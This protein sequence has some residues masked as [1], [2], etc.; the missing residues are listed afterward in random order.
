MPASRKPK[1]SARANPSALPASPEVPLIIRS[2]PPERGDVLALLRAQALALPG[3]TERAVYDVFCKEWTPAYYVGERQLFHVHNFKTGLRGT[4]FVGVRTLLP[5]VLDSEE[6][7]EELRALAA[8][9][10]GGHT[11][12]VKVPL[13]TVDAVV[14]FLE[15]VRV[16]WR[17]LTG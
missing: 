16:K 17:F 11:K 12:Q 8:G 13:D 1:A 5:L 15:L 14:G 4:V 9:A 3:V 7:P 10:R 6:V 2:L